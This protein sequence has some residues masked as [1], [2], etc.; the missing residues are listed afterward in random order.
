MMEMGQR[1]IVLGIDPAVTTGFAVVE[2]GKIG[3]AYAFTSKKNKGF[4]S[5]I[6]RW[7]PY[8]KQLQDLLTHYRP[9]VIVI[10]GYGYGNAHSLALLVELATLYRKTIR[11]YRPDS[12]LIVIPPTVLKKFVTGKG[13]SPKDKIM[14]EVYKRWG[15]EAPDNNVADAVGLAMA[16]HVI[17]GGV[18]DLPVVNLRSLDPVF[19]RYESQINILREEQNHE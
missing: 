18:V 6:D 8:E 15:F 16:G 12:P 9:D 11:M 13:N 14:L 3:E 7:M 10:E 19:K 17:A 5:E 2:R 4:H 1:N